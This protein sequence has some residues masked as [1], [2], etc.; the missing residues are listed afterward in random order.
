MKLLLC[1]IIG[2]ALG[3]LNMALMLSKLKG[4]DIRDEGTGNAGA[5]NVTVIMGKKF[6]IITAVFDMLKASAAVMAAG[7]LFPDVKNAGIIAGSACILGH[8]FPAVVPEGLVVA[9]LHA[10]P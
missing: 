4:F 5:S 2:Y 3:N 1:F 6:G 7:A 10:W 8:I 9:V